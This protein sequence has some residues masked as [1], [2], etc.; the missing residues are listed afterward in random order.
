MEH[1]K[2]ADEAGK[3]EHCKKWQILDLKKIEQQLETLPTPRLKGN[4]IGLE[5]PSLYIYLLEHLKMFKDV[6]KYMSWCE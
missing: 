1:L 3:L 4:F 6:D 5:Y 2:A